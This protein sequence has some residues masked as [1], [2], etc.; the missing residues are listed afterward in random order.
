MVPG[1]SSMLSS[2]NSEKIR[3]EELL[4]R[5]FPA[6]PGIEPPSSVFWVLEL[7]SSSFCS[8]HSLPR[9]RVCS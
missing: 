2:A 9:V 7:G 6:R 8:V 3:A 5:F 1:I 4:L